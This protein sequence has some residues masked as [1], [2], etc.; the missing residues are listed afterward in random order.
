MTIF[1]GFTDRTN[2]HSLFCAAMREQASPGCETSRGRGSLWP[3][4]PS[5]K[6]ARSM[7]ERLLISESPSC[8]L[9]RTVYHWD[10]GFINDKCHEGF[11]WGKMTVC[12]QPRERERQHKENM[13]DN[14]RQV[15][16]EFH[17]LSG[18]SLWS[19][20]LKGIS[21]QSAFPC[22]GQMWYLGLI[23]LKMETR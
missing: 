11:T 19:L 20:P 9:L 4:W 10:A 8:L 16:N 23:H 21:E 5:L 22:S 6:P 17:T 15:G 1:S 12:C 14:P 2:N 18:R 7:E 13:G 3:T